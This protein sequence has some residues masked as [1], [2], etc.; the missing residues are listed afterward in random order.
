MD[1]LPIVR[2]HLLEDRLVMPGA[3]TAV[4]HLMPNDEQPERFAPCVARRWPTGDLIFDHLD[5]DT[6][7]EEEVR[8]RAE[9]GQ[10]IADL[11]SVPSTLRA[12]FG[13]SE[14]ERA[15]EAAA[16]LLHPLEGRALLAQ[17]NAQGPQAASG[18]VESLA[19]RRSELSRQRAARRAPARQQADP[20]RAYARRTGLSRAQAQTVLARSR[21]PGVDLRQQLCVE[22]ALVSVGAELLDLRKRG[23]LLEVRYRFMAERFSTLVEKDSLRVVDAGVCL[24]G[25]DSQLTLESLPSAIREAIRA[26]EL[27][28]TRSAS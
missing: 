9:L 7:A 1:A 23:D 26:G 12:A 16:V 6:Q 5:F 4:V 8:A 25:T 15:A 21:R 22:N 28:I 2:G 17:L 18:L 20:W 27:C 14:L 13:L 3:R 19:A 10:S 24:D 11:K